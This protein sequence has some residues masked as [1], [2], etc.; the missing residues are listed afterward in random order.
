MSAYIFEHSINQK[1]HFNMK[2]S[3]EQKAANLESRRN[4]RKAAKEVNR[5]ESEKNQ[6]PVSD[7]T[8]SITWKKS[9]TG[10]NPTCKAKIRHT[11][12]TCSYATSK[13]GGYGYDKESTVIADIFNSFLKYT[14]WKLDFSKIAN[15]RPT[16]TKNPLP[17]GIHCYSDNRPHFGGG[18]G[19]NCYYAISE[20]I[21]G[22]FEQV[23]SGKMFDVYKFTMLNETNHV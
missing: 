11:D 2:L 7:I 16:K 10:N 14:L 13:A 20:A 21:G 3:T 8:F 1:N 19:V 15:S 12:G 9:S 4:A 6:K 17:Y 5:I 23:A 22:K 18:I